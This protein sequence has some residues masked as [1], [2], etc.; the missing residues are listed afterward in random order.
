MS[1]NSEEDRLLSKKIWSFDL[2]IGSIGYAIRGGNPAHPLEFNEVESLVISHDFASIKEQSA[3]RRIWKTRKA[4]QARENYLISFFESLSL[5]VLKGRRAANVNGNWQLIHTGDE[6]LER[7]FPRKGDSTVY[8]SALLRILLI[9]GQPLEDWQIYKAF[10]SAIQKRGYD[11][12]L[13][14]KSGTQR[15]GRKAKENSEDE[16]DG[17]TKSRCMAMEKLI[18]EQFPK[19]KQYPCYWEAQR[20]GLWSQESGITNRITHHASSIKYDSRR[21][22]ALGISTNTSD[23]VYLPAIYP[24]KL[25]ELELRALYAQAEKQLPALK[26]KVDE[27]LYGKAGIPYASYTARTKQDVRQSL[28][29][30]NIHLV[31]G[32]ESDWQGV[33]S[34]KV[35]T[36]D[37]RSPENC[38]LIPRFH[39]TKRAAKFVLGQLKESS[40]LAAEMSFLMQ[41]KNINFND[42]REQRVFSPEEIRLIFTDIRT[43]A[44]KATDAEKI[45]SHFKL[46]K[47]ELA[48]YIKKF[49]N[50]IYK[51]GLQIESPSSKGRSRFS[52]PALLLIK[53]LILSGKSP[54]E[55]R[56][57]LLSD[58]REQFMDP[59]KLTETDL[60][61][62]NEKNMG[63]TWEHLYIP[64]ASLAECRLTSDLNKE[65][66]IAAIHRLIGKQLDPIVRDRLS[67]ILSLIIKL[68]KKHG[69]PDH[70]VLEFVREDFLGKKAKLKLMKRQK[71]LREENAENLNEAQGNYKS[72]FKRRLMKEQG[73]IC[74]YTGKPL[75]Q[76][77]LE[78]EELHIDHIVPRE[79][80]G[81]NALYNYV[82][83]HR[84]TNEEKKKRTPYQW[85]K[86]SEHW[87]A[88]LLRVTSLKTSLGTKKGTL[89]TSE[90][91]EELVERY[92]S[93]AETAW[94]SKL[95]QTIFC[96][97]FGWNLNFEN[98]VRRVIVIPGALT[99]KIAKKEKLYRLLGDEALHIEQESILANKEASKEE[100]IKAMKEM[101]KKNR[102]DSRHHALDAMILSF[103]PGWCAD[104]TK[105][106]YYRLP[107][108]LLNQGGAL[109]WFNA[110]L[111]DVVPRDM[112]RS[113]P[114]MEES[115][116]GQ[117]NNKATR[118]YSV[119]SLGYK[120][121]NNK[122]IYDAGS[123]C[124]NKE[125]IVSSKAKELI[126][127][128]LEE[129]PSPDEAT[130]LHFCD[131]FTFHPGGSI[132]KNLKRIV[133]QNLDEFHSF[134]KD[135]RNHSF[136]KAKTHKG[137]FIVKKEWRKKTLY[138]A[139][140]VFAFEA[141]EERRK[142]IEMQAEYEIVSYLQNGMIFNMKTIIDEKG[143]IIL[144]A[145]KYKQ[146]TIK[147]GR[148][149]QL[150]SSNN[151]LLLSTTKFWE[152][153]I[154]I[155]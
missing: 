83:T 91:A 85:L 32:K 154:N 103:I 82:L 152:H 13:P 90:K 153:L 73:G 131:T 76:D 52:K 16:E 78:N 113:K 77:Q 106:I 50:A 70:V 100:R 150:V 53:E 68:E 127:L 4:Y 130:W 141:K 123:I 61:V 126:A 133:S 40:L 7:E 120:S 96:L 58:G 17:K 135:G 138:N 129:N 66:R 81:P 48:D 142:I 149:I 147:S 121:N 51:E 60:D 155:E 89:L 102:N 134:A 24:R 54:E 94:I 45:V 57:Y 132:V 5:P 47:K 38:K 11:P 71:K 59:Y 3:R 109:K 108:A 42:G 18:K 75:S 128:F 1:I 20:M 63:N 107:Q 80:G 117:N 12:D 104:K 31:E 15:S 25:V 72:A 19:G 101:E 151:D 116:Y 98:D 124:K 87:D 122:L 97:Y 95:T 49:S 92:Q 148:Q 56:T 140:P 114:Q 62:F 30:R 139:L 14:W 64:D 37:N 136:K 2:G 44:L 65:Q 110:Y 105:R 88:Y 9:E 26:G 28:H 46:T 21:D 144:M 115:Y 22:P 8:N 41:L 99:N 69:Q 119:K 67:R 29:H 33:L 74:L 6:R 43:K 86:A 143:K 93:L 55:F 39:V 145:G 79:M 35:P 84:S 125:K 146:A 27:F 111:Q 34:Q 112:A 10:R 118:R 36:F 23:H 137:W